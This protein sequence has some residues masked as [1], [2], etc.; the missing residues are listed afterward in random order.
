MKPLSLFYCMWLIFLSLLFSC[1]HHAG[2][3]GTEQA[4]ASGLKGD[5]AKSNIDSSTLKAKKE[6]SN[7][8]AAWSVNE[9]ASKVNFTIKNFG[10]DVHGSLGGLK[11][12]IHFDEKNLKASSFEASVKVNTIN[13]GSE[14]RDRDLMHPKYFDGAN[15]PEITFKSDNIVSSGKAYKTIGTL[16][17]KGKSLRKEIPFT[18]EE[19]GNS[20]I[21]KS[22][23]ILQRL[24]Y[25]VGGE[26]PIMGKDVT[27]SL[28]IV[29]EKK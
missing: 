1:N 20:G 14:K 8:P 23:F 22:E 25:G 24:D 2:N 27:V 6:K 9:Q 26:G 13:T 3:Q 16:T 21:F 5:S 19:K 15:Y 4:D 18:F 11:S 7:Q 10:N 12:T 28:E 17:I 29:A